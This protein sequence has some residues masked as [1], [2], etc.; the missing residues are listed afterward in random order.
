MTACLLGL[1]SNVG[2]RPGHLHAALAALA[3]HPELRLVSVSS[4]YESAPVG[5]PPDQRPFLN[6]AAIVDTHLS[7]RELVAALL[8]IE[9][10]LGRVRKEKW[11]PRALDI[12]LL[13]YGRQILESADVTVPH[14]RLHERRFA[15]APAAEIAADWP[16]PLRGQTNAQLLA[17]LGPPRAGELGLR[18][19][20]S[21]T[22]MQQLVGELRDAG[23]RIGLVPTMGALHA[24]HLSLVEAARRRADDVVATIFV[25]P[26]QF[27]PSEDLQKYPR[28]L[29]ADLEALSAAG[30]GYCFVPTADTMYPPGFSTF[31]EPPSVAHVLEGVSRP[32]H[33]RGVATIVLKLFQIV[34]A[35]F[36]C[37]GE[38]DYQQ[39][40]VI[41]RMVEDL[42][43][44]I[45]IV[46]CP[47][48][49]WADGLAMSSRNRYLS[50]A[51]R[52]QALAISQ[53]L[54]RAADLAASGE[55]NEAVVVQAM[56][57]VLRDAGITRI[58]YAAIV[59]P[60]TLVPIAALDRPAR[61]LIAAHVG[62][63]RLIDNAPLPVLSTEY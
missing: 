39:L 52:K 21:P 38:K 61:A 27:G 10:Q 23:R 19:V 6:A 32:G 17:A 37:F 9:E 14:P 15:L 25:N 29:D 40:Q 51:E 48:V 22:A 46:A 7:P 41:R 42:N 35:H 44:P 58:D 34:P 54:Q 55:R 49:R 33:F 3:R 31:V 47:T 16:H 20:H 59:D 2:D 1:G 56:H 60:D 63:T 28:T 12:D 50:P 26:T 8:A 5:G 62:S 45:E 53:A 18:V 11:G 43:V 13:L 36:A 4:F 57:E 30:C 24:G